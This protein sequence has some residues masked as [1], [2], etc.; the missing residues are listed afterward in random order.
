MPNAFPFN[1]QVADGLNGS[2]PC[3]PSR[4]FNFCDFDVIQKRFPIEYLQ[5]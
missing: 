3:V 4:V 2:K 5:A 1:A